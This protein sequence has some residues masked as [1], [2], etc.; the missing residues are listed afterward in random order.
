MANEND[1]LQ[2]RV[3]ILNGFSDQEII[4]IM[5]MVKAVYAPEE[6]ERY[7]AF[8]QAAEKL[9]E[10]TE[11]AKRLL[12]VAGAAKQTPESKSVSTGDLIFAKTTENSLQVR[13]ADLIEDMSEDHEYLKKNPPKASKGKEG[14]S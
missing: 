10:A 1:A 11:F 5:N 7:T 3:L 12:K 9:P 13:L 2:N 4:A 14:K 6:M 8:V